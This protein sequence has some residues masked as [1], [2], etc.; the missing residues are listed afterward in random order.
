CAVPLDAVEEI[1]ALPPDFRPA[2]G[3]HA[4]AL[5]RMAWRGGALPLLSLDAILGA[6]AA[7][8]GPSHR[9]AILRGAAGPVGLVAAAVGPVLRLARE[10]VDPLPRA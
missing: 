8:T 2:P 1:A 4:A 3:P 7:P 6:D 9:V 5:G 10:A